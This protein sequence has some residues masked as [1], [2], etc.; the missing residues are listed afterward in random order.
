MV[1]Q[2]ASNVR[3][4]GCSMGAPA[5]FRDWR[6]AH[7]KH[8]RPLQNVFGGL[9]KPRRIYRI[10]GFFTEALQPTGKVGHPP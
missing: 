9:Q 7:G 4:R 6:L 3:S 5:E 2:C 8:S 10:A 1:G